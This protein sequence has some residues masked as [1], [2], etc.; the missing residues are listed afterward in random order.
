MF[1]CCIAFTA[2][3]SRRLGY[4]KYKSVSEE[5]TKCLVVLA[6]NSL[7][8]WG[9]PST[10]L[11]R[12]KEM[13]DC[14]IGSKFPGRVKKAGVFQVV[15]KAGIFQ[16]QISQRR[17]NKMFDCCIAFTAGRVKEAG[18]FQ[19]QVRQRRRNKM[20]CC[21]GSK[22]PRRDK[23]AGVVQVQ[24]CEEETKCLIDVLAVSSLEG[25]RITSQPRRTKCLTVVL[26]VKSMRRNLL[27]KVQE[28]NYSKKESHQLYLLITA[29]CVREGRTKCLIVDLAVNSFGRSLLPEGS[30][31]QVF[32]EGSNERIRGIWVGNFWGEEAIHH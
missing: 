12:R 11:R 8:G 1:D 25:S 29:S 19:V 13:F 31:R 14:C 22:L 7:E 20:S 2:G 16:V 23:K 9:I 6:V 18:V 28:Y 3:G 21:I 27:P 17:R 5:E 26:T 4:S 15:N 30:R 10:N 32:Q 24:I